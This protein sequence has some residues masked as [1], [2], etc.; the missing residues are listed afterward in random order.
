MG[1]DNKSASAVAEELGE[2]LK[3][4]RLN[5]NKTQAEVAELVGVS[6]KPF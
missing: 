1:F 6:R 3:Q 4:A 2:R 5:Q